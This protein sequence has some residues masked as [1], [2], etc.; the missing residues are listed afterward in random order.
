LVTFGTGKGERLSVNSSGVRSDDEGFAGHGRLGG[1][2]F[3]N[4]H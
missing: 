3:N 2:S 4:I 1:I